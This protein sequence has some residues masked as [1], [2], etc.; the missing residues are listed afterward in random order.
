MSWDHA[1]INHLFT[2]GNVLALA[3][4]GL[5]IFV[6]RWRGVAQAVAT[7]VV[8]TLLSVAYSALI[9]VWWS[10]S[11][12]GFGSL[13]DVHTLF[14]TRGALLAGWLHYLAFDLLV[15]AGIAR[16]SRRE[17]VPHLVVIPILILT[18]LF[19]PIG[20]LASMIV[21]SARQIA[22]SPP[23]RGSLNSG[24]SLSGP[25]VRALTSLAGREPRLIAS[26]FVCF[27]VMIPLSVAA[28][29]DNRTLAEVNVGSSP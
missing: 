9:G 16:Q 7:V 27:A 13:D 28:V 26:A 24:V 22:E 19:G 4:W 8:P 14:Q 21:R 29:L 15:G 11:E 5:L 20:Y 25:A 12:G 6:P 10:R 18:F 17:G 1:V 23:G 3:A 2:G